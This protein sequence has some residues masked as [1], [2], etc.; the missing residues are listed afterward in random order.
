MVRVSPRQA[1]FLTV[2]VSLLPLSA[3]R[4]QTAPATL[5]APSPPLPTAT[6]APP[7]ATGPVGDLAPMPDLGV[8]WPD[9]ARIDA[10]PA[11][12]G[13]TEV[14]G[15]SADKLQHYRTALEGAESLGSTFRTRFDQLSALVANQ[16]KPANAAQINRRAEDDE[17][18]VRQLLA[19]QGHYDGR[20]VTT[21]NSHPETGET[22]VHEKVT[23]GEAYQF[24]AVSLPGLEAAGKE[25]PK[26]A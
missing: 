7:D 19:A 13:P 22:I 2:A 23:P 18:L 10:A 26:L 24:S 17:D 21:V 6:P 15:I 11:A 20:V 5:V 9:P 3:A 25:A 1:V 8:D 4:G 12:S 16:G 14:K